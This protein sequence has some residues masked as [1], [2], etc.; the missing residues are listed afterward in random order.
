MDLVFGS[1]R[2]SSHFS[3]NGF[4]TSPFMVSVYVFRSIFGTVPPIV[5][6]SFPHLKSCLMGLWFGGKTLLLLFCSLGGMVF[7]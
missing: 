5:G 4:S 6:W 3:F 7:L 2:M 1:F